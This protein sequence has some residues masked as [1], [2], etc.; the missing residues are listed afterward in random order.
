MLPRSSGSLPASV[1]KLKRS[2]IRRRKLEKQQNNLDLSEGSGD[3]VTGGDASGDNLDD[4]D[5]LYQSIDDDLRA[6]K[7]DSSVKR[8]HLKF[9]KK[10]RARPLSAFVDSFKFSQNVS[11]SQFVK[12]MTRMVSLKIFLEL[13]LI[14]R[15]CKQFFKVNGTVL[16]PILLTFKFKVKLDCF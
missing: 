2:P 15:T 7:T 6:L 5:T 8:R 11:F 16:K 10:I 12:I 13:L 9:G 1:L 3:D 4:A 14:Y